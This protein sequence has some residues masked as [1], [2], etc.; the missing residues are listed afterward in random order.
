[1]DSTYS[2]IKSAIANKLV[3][4]A[5]YDGHYREMCPHVLGLNKRGEYQALFYQF[6]GTSKS[7]LGPPGSFDNWRCVPLAELS[8]VSSREGEWRTATNHSRPQTCVKVIHA[9]VDW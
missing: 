3:I 1:M 2:I 8:M 6:G 4:T 9:V 7:G 5:V